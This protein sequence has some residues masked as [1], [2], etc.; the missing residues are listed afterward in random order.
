MSQE[1]KQKPILR[2]VRMFEPDRMASVNLQVAYEKVIP[3]EQYQILSSKKEAE[4]S[5]KI[6]S[7]E[8]E[9]SV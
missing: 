1:R 5:N 9:V 7:V 2:V 3:A 6:L 4:K 8:K